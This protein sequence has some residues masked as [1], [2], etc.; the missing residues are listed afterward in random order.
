MSGDYMYYDANKKLIQVRRNVTLEDPQMVLTTDF[1]DY[2]AANRVGYY[3][4]K[5]TIKDSI[6][7]LISDIGYYYLPI[8]EMFF[9]DSVKVYTPEY[10]MYSDTLKYQTETKVI[11]ILGP[12]NIY[13]DIRRTAGITH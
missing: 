13:G 12:T 7:T 9:K 1:L 6:N 5:G 2:D 3:F 8:N 10:T 4:N 11:T